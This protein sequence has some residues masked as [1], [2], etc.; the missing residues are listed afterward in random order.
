MDATETKAL[1]HGASLVSASKM[2]QRWRHNLLG[3]GPPAS[4]R[5]PAQH[6][7]LRLP[8]VGDNAAMEAE[9]PKAAPPKPPLVEKSELRALW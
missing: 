3:L 6:P 8:T 4:G 9:P 7:L 2:V 5:R 1:K